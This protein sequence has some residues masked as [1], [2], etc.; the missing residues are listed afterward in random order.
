MEQ[1]KVLAQQATPALVIAVD[2]GLHDGAVQAPGGDAER[3]M[4]HERFPD[5]LAELPESVEERR[6]LR[7]R[8]AAATPPFSRRFGLL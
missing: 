1:V 5:D 7:N 8:P 6:R 2:D 3:R 4:R